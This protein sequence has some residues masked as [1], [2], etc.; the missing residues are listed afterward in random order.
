MAP[1][2]MHDIVMGG[3]LVIISWMNSRKYEIS[4]NL[5]LAGWYLSDYDIILDFILASVV[6]VVILF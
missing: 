3:I 6:L 1:I 4:G 2:K 5:I